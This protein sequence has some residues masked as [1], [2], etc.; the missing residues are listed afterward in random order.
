MV[1]RVFWQGWVV[2]AM[3]AWGTPAVAGDAFG[4]A[5]SAVYEVRYGPS[6]LAE[7]GVETSCAE[8][9]VVTSRLTAASRGLA[10][11]IHPFQVRLDTRAN[12][13]GGRSERSQTFIHE[14]GVSRRYRSQFDTSPQVSTEAQV[15]GRTEREQVGLPRVGQD[16]L[17]WMLHLRLDVAREGALQGARRY[18]LWD[19]WK[20]VY[21]DVMPGDVE[22]VWTPVGEVEAQAFRLRRTRLEQAGAG[23]ERAEATEELGTLWI[24]TSPRALP[25]SMSFRAPIGSVRIEIQELERR[26]CGT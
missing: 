11:R 18:A 16:L 5:E 15:R 19:G 23:W 7:M 24:E 6:H 1:R 4:A 9:G 26:S 2:V 13:D 8:D 17:S 3:M 20:L 14:K 10:R 12:V 21:L 25:V 22:E